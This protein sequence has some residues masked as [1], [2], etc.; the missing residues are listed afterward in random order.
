[1][2]LMPR[3]L[4]RRIALLSLSA[5][6]R[7]GLMDG[8]RQA[9][10]PCTW[11]LADDAGLADV[12]IVD[13]DDGAAM[14]RLTRA[15]LLPRTLSIGALSRPGVRLH[16]LRPI[17][18]AL[19]VAAVE[20]WP[21][22]ATGVAP[23]AAAAATPSP[24]SEAA[25]VLRALARTGTPVLDPILV[26]D[27]HTESLRFMQAQLHRFGFAVSLCRTVADAHARVAERAYDF[28]FVERRLLQE[29]ADSD[30]LQALRDA[31][32]R[33]PRQPTTWV[34]LGA[35][36][37][38]PEGC[39]AALARPLREDA[40]YRVIGEREIAQHAFARTAVASTLM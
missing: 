20:G 30:A 8:F 6:E 16:L 25:R 21:R 1:M 37:G 7:K 35:I 11:S 13:G 26:I 39:D 31:A 33:P 4:P 14:D 17:E 9:R 34:L 38:D 12:V 19:V 36:G 28:V 24:G 32:A 10:F 23:A 5:F 40:L 27:D 29:Q 18:V 15:G 3:P 22:P 2:L